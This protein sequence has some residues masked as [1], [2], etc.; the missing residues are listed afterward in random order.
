MTHGNNNN[1]GH[2]TMEENRTV[3]YDWRALDIYALQERLTG[4]IDKGKL[5]HGSHENNL[6]VL[7]PKYS[8][9][10]MEHKGAATAVFATDQPLIA[11]AK[12]VAGRSLVGWTRQVFFE[13]DDGK[14]PDYGLIYVLSNNGFEPHLNDSSEYLSTNSVVPEAKIVISSNAVRPIFRSRTEVLESMDMLNATIK[15][16]SVRNSDVDVALLTFQNQLTLCPFVDG[17]TNM[18]DLRYQ[19]F[20]RLKNY[21]EPLAPVFERVHEIATPKQREIA[22]NV[23]KRWEQVCY[24]VYDGPPTA[25]ETYTRVLPLMQKLKNV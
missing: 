1:E 17:E 9:D 7:I 23:Y 21:A 10:A 6:T 5:L 12:G 25:V 3:E 14:L 2:S 8:E 19:N 13:L 4:L 22:R 18:F 15:A 16:N 20:E 11:M 24:G